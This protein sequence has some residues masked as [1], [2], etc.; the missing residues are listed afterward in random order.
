MASERDY[1]ADLLV[2]LSDLRDAVVEFHDRTIR[3]DGGNPG[4]R[5][6]NV[7][8]LAIAR[9]WTTAFCEEIY[10]T[11]YEKAS[12]I[13]ESIVCHH[14]FN[15]GNHRSAL[16]AAYLVLGL[17]GLVLTAQKDETLD[18]IRNLEAGTL[19]VPA[20]GEWLEQRCVLRSNSAFSSEPLWTIPNISSIAAV[21]FVAGL[22]TQ[23]RW[24]NLL[25][26]VA[27]WVEDFGLT[28]LA[29]KAG[30]VA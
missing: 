25:L 14:V 7:L 12:A 29:A 13:A 19:S 3:D 22:T 28:G 27:N 4:I 2:Y 21:Q 24:A 8:Q 17:T 9:P 10:K 30:A 6:E 20:F 1:Q 23:L 15:D 5:D 11:P 26:R 18:A 16:G